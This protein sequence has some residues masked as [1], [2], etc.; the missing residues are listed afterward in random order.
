MT[1]NPQLKGASLDED[2]PVPSSVIPEA[3]WTAFGL[4]PATTKV[5]EHGHGLINLTYKFLVEDQP[6]LMVQRINTHVFQNPEGLMGN[7]VQIL[8]KLSGPLRLIKTVD[9]QTHVTQPEG[10]WR[11]Y[12]YITNSYVL[13]QL[14]NSKQAALIGKAF[15]NF[16]REL[17]ELPVDSLEETI[18]GFHDT[19]ARYEKLIQAVDTAKP[20][21][22]KLAQDAIEKAHALNDLKHAYEKY[23]LPLRIVHNDTKVNN[24]LLCADTH[25]PICIID[26]DTVMPGTV[27]NDFGDLVR[28]SA[29]LLLEDDPD[30]AGQGWNRDIL[31]SLKSGYL[32]VANDFLTEGERASLEEAPKVLIYE[33]AL[34][35]LTDYL[36]GDHYFKTEYPTHNLVRA[37]NQFALVESY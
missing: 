25:D 6:P 31:G 14:S 36:E 22:H 28:T 24:V 5:F 27:A 32:E 33:L 34:R 3:I 12:N 10:V 17:S 7:L 18:P 30:I 4:N 26:L 15:A 23:D 8:D 2:R 1:V 20:E 37:L 35:F 21:R 29:S 9:Q 11:A 19:V 13:S 16:H